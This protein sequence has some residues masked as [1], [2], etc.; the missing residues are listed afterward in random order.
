MLIVYLIRFKKSHFSYFHVVWFWSVYFVCRQGWIRIPK[1][2]AKLYT[3]CFFCFVY[4][5]IFVFVLVVFWRVF[6]ISFFSCNR[7]AI[8]MLSFKDQNSR[9]N[10]RGYNRRIH[11]VRKMCST[12]QML[13]LS[14]SLSGSAKQTTIVMIINCG[15]IRPGRSNRYPNMLSLHLNYKCMEK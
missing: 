6:N 10:M 12:L 7:Q 11:I 13:S 1:I 2:D 4:I 5:S 14:L 3:Y 9:E 15:R 8:L